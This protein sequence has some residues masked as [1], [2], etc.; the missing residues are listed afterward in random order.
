M[1]PRT[2]RFVSVAAQQPE[3]KL[4][5]QSRE[6]KGCAVLAALQDGNLCRNQI[7]PWWVLSAIYLLNL[8]FG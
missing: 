1:F 2:L 8:N 3:R 5:F 6:P 7:P 4:L